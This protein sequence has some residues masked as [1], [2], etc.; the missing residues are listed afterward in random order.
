MTRAGELLAFVPLALAL[1]VGAFALARPPQGGVAGAAGG[2]GGDALVTLAAAPASYARLAEDWTEAPAPEADLAGLPAPEPEPESVPR[3]ELLGAATPRVALPK[4]AEP[5][6]EADLPAPSAKPEAQRAPDPAPTLRPEAR[7]ARAA[8][9]APPSEARAAQVARGRAE[10]A[11]AG[12]GATGGAPTLT[13]ARASSLQ[14]EWGARILARVDRSHR[15]PRGTRASGRALIELVLARD[16]QLV[17]ARLVQS[18]GD[19]RLDEAALAAVRRAGRFP[20]APRGLAAARYSFTLP[21]RF[22]WQ[23]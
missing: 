13:P 8:R 17:S 23:G 22:E 21:L 16:G 4:L 6:P 20:P 12:A 18:A 10:A 15:Y 14:A 11:E 5:R 9:P 19:P 1:H 7:P 2:P 3:A